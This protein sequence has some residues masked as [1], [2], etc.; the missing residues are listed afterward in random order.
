M[1]VLVRD[2]ATAARD[3]SHPIY[4][5]SEDA[6][7]GNISRIFLTGVPQSVPT[8]RCRQPDGW[9]CGPYS[10][11]ECLGQGDGEDA[12]RWL[13]DRGMITSAYGTEYA[14]MVGY[15]NSCGYTCGY[16]GRA[17]DAEMGGSAFDAMINHLQ[18]GYKVILCMHGTSKGCRTN[19]WTRG[20]HYICLYGIEGSGISVDGDWGPETTKRAQKV[21]GTEVDGIVS[22][23]NNLMIKNLPNCYP[24]SWEFVKQKKLKNGSTLVKAIQKMLGIAEDGFFGMGTIVTFQSWLGVKT[25]GFVGG[26]TVRAFQR[27]LNGRS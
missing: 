2:P 19:Y 7:N 6:L 26:E 1:N 13:L 25:D 23:Q 3:G 5:E 12:R 22:N 4:G 15:L 20:G 27:W 10:L 24:S 11:A 21:F 9:S 8:T 14:G 16:D 18:S 17:H